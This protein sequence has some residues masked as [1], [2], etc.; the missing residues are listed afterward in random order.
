M[1]HIAIDTREQRPWAF[2][3]HEAKTEIRTLPT[4]D[5]CLVLEGGELDLGF[6]VERKSLSDL[7]G[8]LSTGWERF[9]NEIRRMEL[10][11]I[12]LIVVEGSDADIVNGE[13]NHPKVTPAFLS[14]QIC[15][16]QWKGVHVYF[17]ETPARAAQVAWIHLYTRHLQLTD[18]FFGEEWLQKN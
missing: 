4:G 18:P 5:Y 11:P 14:R 9:K 15:I 8:T 10:Y 16:L 17:A 2:P 13:F 1:L 6:S 3:E 7:A 12:R